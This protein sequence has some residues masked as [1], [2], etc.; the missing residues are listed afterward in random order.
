MP[1]WRNGRRTRLKILRG[2]PHVGSTPT[3]GTTLKL[4]R[5]VEFFNASAISIQGSHKTYVL[6]GRGPTECKGEVI[7]VA[8]DEQKAIVVTT[9]HKTQN[10]ARATSCR[11]DPSCQT[12]T[13]IVNCSR[14]WLKT[15]INCFLNASPHRHHQVHKVVAYTT[16]FFMSFNCRFLGR[17]RAPSSHKLQICA[18]HQLKTCRWHLFLTRRPIGTN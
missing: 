5:K 7:S 16:A 12:R 17:R 3:I 6:K 18:V 15:I 10:L 14:L 2:Q 4:N 13:A 1:M 8:N 11:F 9:T